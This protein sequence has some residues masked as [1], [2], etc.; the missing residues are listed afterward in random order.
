MNRKAAVAGQFYSGSKESLNKDLKILFSKAKER[1]QD[2]R[3]IISPH[4]G[5]IFSGEIAASAINQINPNKKYKNIFI[6]ASSHTKYF[7]GA[8]IYNIGNYETPLGEVKVNIE[9]CNELIK[10]NEIFSFVHDAHKTEHSIEVQLPFLQYHLKNDFQ[11]IPIVI[12]FDGEE[13]VKKIADALKAY[14][15]EENIFIV[16][17]DFSHYPSYNDA[18]NIDLATAN[19]IVSG[20]PEELIKIVNTKTGIKNLST[21]CCAWNSVL[22]LMY[23]TNEEYAFNKIHYKNSGDS[24]YGSDDRVVGYWA[25]SVTNKNN[26]EF[27]LSDKEKIELLQLARL[28]AETKIIENKSLEIKDIKVSENLNEKCGA[29]VTF[30]KDSNLRGCIGRFEPNIPL[31]Q[32]VIEMAVSAATED[33]RFSPISKQ[34]LDE[35]EI[36]ISVLTPF[37]KIKSIDE[38]ELGKHGIYIV[39]NGRAGTFLPQVAESTGWDLEEFLGHC[40][41]DKAGIGYNGWK[42]ADIYTY[43]AIVFS[44]SDFIKKNKNQAKYYEKLED[45]RIHCTLCPHECKLSEGKI[46]RCKTRQNINGE[47]ISLSYG[48]LVAIHIDPIEKKP[49]Y[50]FLPGSSSFSLGTAG[51]NMNCKN[52]Q[53]S[54]IS[55]NSPLQLEYIEATPEQIVA[56]AKKNKCES[57]AYTYTEPTVFY[58]FVLETAKLAKEN[59]IKNIIISN[60]FINPEPLKELI[61]YLDAA[62]IDLKA[63]KDSIYRDITSASLEPILNNLK[64]LLDSDVWLEITNLIIPNH[65]DDMEMIAEMCDWLVENNFAE[66]PLHFSRFFPSYKM[67]NVPPTPVATVEQAAQIAKSKG[68]KY[69]YLGNVHQEEGNTNCSNCGQTLIKRKTYKTETNEFSGKCKNC[70]EIINGIWN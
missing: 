62:N 70:G 33:Y 15:N 5:Y 6:I 29:F 56:S 11:I 42:D 2:A 60:G 34:E 13:N 41:R 1:K 24:P 31:Y 19:A 59:G 25:I 35:V 39:K 17:T 30:N 45:G 58:E 20:K 43:E 4:A 64:I 38:I 27:S 3:A 21:N 7:P 50:H 51:C 67:Q 53:N 44:E 55:Q 46:G 14:W 57:I 54:E 61:P 26:A 68:I 69:V 32:V 10:N 65:T 49:L 36:E 37:K 22:S 47:L 23:L 28:S 66:T 52:C 40:A 8:S 48:N 9:I 18:V 12:G 63:F 16:S